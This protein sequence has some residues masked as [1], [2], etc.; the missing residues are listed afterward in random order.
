MRKHLVMTVTGN[1]RVGIVEEVTRLI[2]D[3]HG[4]VDRSQM[5]RLGGEFTMLMLVSVPAGQFTDLREGVRALRDSGFKIS[6]RETQRGFSS[7]FATWSSWQVKVD[8]ADHEGIIHEVTRFLARQGINIEAMETGMEQMAMSG[9]QLFTMRSTVVVPP[10]M[11][12]NELQEHLEAIGQRLNVDVT[13][14]KR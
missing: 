2:L 5:V 8:G 10:D 9:G 14:A 13:V 6:T 12:M 4:N 7:R 3:Y 1:D 11:D